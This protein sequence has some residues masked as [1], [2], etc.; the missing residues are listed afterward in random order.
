MITT[1][2]A[3]LAA[4]A[5]LRDE[6]GRHPELVG[7]VLAGST[8][9]RAAEEPHPPGSDEDLFIYVRAEA[10]SEILEPHGRLAAAHILLGFV[11][12]I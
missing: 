11:W 5:W 9:R 10:P 2:E 1:R 6:A 8:R 4:E 7:A 12:D 3:R